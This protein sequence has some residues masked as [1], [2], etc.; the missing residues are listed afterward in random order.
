MSNATTSLAIFAILEYVSESAFPEAGTLT[1]TVVA[2]LLP[3]SSLWAAMTNEVDISLN[4]SRLSEARS[5][6]SSAA[7]KPTIVPDLFGESPDRTL[8]T[9]IESRVDGAA[10]NPSRGDR[11]PSATRDST[12]LDLEA[13]GVRVE[14]SYSV[15]SSKALTG[16]YIH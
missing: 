9:T 13:M 3:L 15:H 2:L 1:L 14:S 16:H 11:R 12:E 5:H 8:I 4:L 10:T 7:A 6:V